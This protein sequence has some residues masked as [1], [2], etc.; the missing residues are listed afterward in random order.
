MRIHTRAAGRQTIYIEKALL[1]HP[2]VKKIVS[3]FNSPC[4]IQCDTYREV[5]NP[6]KNSFRLQKHH[7]ALILA[8]KHNNYIQPSPYGI[9][10]E[11]NFYF[12]HMLNCIYDCSYCFLQAFYASAHYVIFVNFEDFFTSIGRKISS[13]KEKECYFFSGYDCDSLAYDPITRFTDQALRFFSSHPRAFLELR[14]KSVQIKELS[15]HK[16][17]PNCIVAFSLAPDQVAAMYEKGIPSPMRRISAMAKLAKQG[18]QV[19]VRLDPL[20]WHTAWREN[21][22]SLVDKLAGSVAVES[23]HS[24]TLGTLRFPKGLATNMRRQHPGADFLARKMITTDAVLRMEKEAHQ[25]IIEFCRR[26]LA[27]YYPKDKIILNEN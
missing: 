10:G 22:R 1:R 26:E 20:I 24:I 15:K 11:N 12:S 27:H 16:P 2:S 8:K 6:K 25:E 9:G 5:F 14:T 21:Y 7:P 4:V 19:G 18:W 3:K 13:M 23:M 17:F